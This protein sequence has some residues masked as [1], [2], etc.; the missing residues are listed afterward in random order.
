M[1]SFLLISLD[2]VKT[3]HVDQYLVK[4][5]RVKAEQGESLIEEVGAKKYFKK[6]L[7]YNII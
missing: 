4:N 2:F 1:F 5:L 6:C 7:N 3:W